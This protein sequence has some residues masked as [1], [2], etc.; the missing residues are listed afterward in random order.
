MRLLFS[1]FVCILNRDVPRQ[2]F[3]KNIPVMN[4]FFLR[5][6]LKYIHEVV[7]GI[8]TIGQ[9]C[10][11]H[12]VNSSAGLSTTWR[13]AQHPILAAYGEWPDAVFSYVIGYAAVPVLKVV[14]EAGPV[15]QHIFHGFRYGRRLGK[16]VQIAFKVLKQSQYPRPGFCLSLFLALISIHISISLFQLKQP[17]NLFYGFPGNRIPAVCRARRQRIHKFP[18][19]M[20]IAEAVLCF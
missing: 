1:L 19:G 10:F 3:L 15:I 13:P 9:T 11:N 20:S 12:A 6:M 2:V 17:V 18:A 16:S 8:N 4:I 7:P 5:H 14:H